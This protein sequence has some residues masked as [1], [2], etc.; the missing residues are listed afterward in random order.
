MRLFLYRL[1]RRPGPDPAPPAEDRW[2][3]CH[4]LAGFTP[5]RLSDDRTRMENLDGVAWYQAPIPSARHRCTP[6]TRGHIDWFTLVFRCACGAISSDG[7]RW[8]QRNTRTGE[9]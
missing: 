6:Q 3:L 2:V 8:V 5:R 4:P 7:E 1:A 9:G